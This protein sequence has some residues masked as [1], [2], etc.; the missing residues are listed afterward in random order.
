VADLSPI[1]VNTLLPHQTVLLSM[2]APGR[3]SEAAARQ[4]LAM[5]PPAGWSNPGEFWRN[6]A[7]SALGVAADAQQQ[8]QVRTDWFVLDISARVEQTEFFQTS[9][10]DARLQPSK[11]VQRRWERDGADAVP[12]AAPAR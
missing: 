11:L 7:V 4:V 3:L 1:N 10:V 12:L 8:V 6:P 9:L 5:R 2:L